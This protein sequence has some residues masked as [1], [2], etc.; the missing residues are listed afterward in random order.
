VK[1]FR[2]EWVFPALGVAFI[3]AS[4]HGSTRDELAAQAATELHCGSVSI[5]RSSATE[6]LATGCGQDMMYTC[7][8]D[9]IC[10]ANAETDRAKLANMA[11][12][13]E[14]SEAVA[15]ALV[16]MACGCASAGLASHG[17]HASHSS[18]SRVSRKK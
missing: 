10:S 1:I 17:S 14:A 5:V 11:D 3:T 8:G 13:S 7:D 2:R 16:D 4:A 6:F 9:G 18:S 15:D 12:Q